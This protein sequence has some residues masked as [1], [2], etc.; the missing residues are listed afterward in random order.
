MKNR[1]WLIYRRVFHSSHH[2]PLHQGQCKYVHGHTYRMEICARPTA[3]SQMNLC[4]LCP[5]MVMDFASFRATIDRKVADYDH[6]DLNKALPEEPTVETFASVLWA[7]IEGLG[8][9]IRYLRLM[10]TDSCGVYLEA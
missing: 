7:D 3:K 10:E 2:L 4:K 6:A 5:T 8:F 1:E 9:E